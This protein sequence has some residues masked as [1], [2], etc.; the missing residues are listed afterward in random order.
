[1]PPALSREYNAELAEVTL[2]H[3]V[4]NIYTAEIEAVSVLVRMHD[5]AALAD[6][7]DVPPSVVRQIAAE[8]ARLEDNREAIRQERGILDKDR[9]EQ[10]QVVV[11]LEAQLAAMS[12][13]KANLKKRILTQ[14]TE[15][16]RLRR[17]AGEVPKLKEELSALQEASSK[18]NPQFLSSTV[19]QVA[20]L[21]MAKPVMFDQLHMTLSYV[22]EFFPFKPKEFGVHVTVVEPPSFAGFRWDQEVDQLV[23]EEGTAL[24]VSEILPELGNM[25][26]K[27]PWFSDEEE[28]E[29]EGSGEKKVE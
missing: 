19:F 7:A 23:F 1:L 21:K 20:A 13:E 5:S 11:D 16:K 27:T 4:Q 9:E 3:C 24:S 18:T 26:P 6:G 8:R 22:S 15:V 29:E 14:E 10:A 12:A 2:A 28:E 25:Q 17:D